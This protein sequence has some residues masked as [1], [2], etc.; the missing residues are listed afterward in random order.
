MTTLK[1]AM[2]AVGSATSCE[3]LTCG[4]HSYC[5]MEKSSGARCMCKDGYQGDGFVCKTAE[6][7]AL[8]SLSPFRPD[9]R[10]MQIADVHVSAIQGDTIMTVY[11]D[12]TDNHRGYAMLGHAS[13]DKMVW[14]P[15]TLF[16]RD[17]QAFSPVAVQLIEGNEALKRGGIAIAYRDMNRGGDGILLSGRIDH[18]SGKLLLGSPRAFAK[19]QAQT[20]SMLALPGSRV[21]IF[22]ASHNVA[23][24]D[25][26][27]A[28]GGMHG[29][30]M[31]A[32]AHP[33][34]SPPEVI[35]KKH[36][37]TGPVARLAATL[38]SP[39]SFVIA[40]RQGASDADS[41]L[42]EAACNTGELHDNDV[43]FGLSPLLLEP[44]Q[45]QI[46]SRSV[47]LIAENTV[48]YTYHSGHEGLTKQAIIK[49]DPSSHLLEVVHG[50]ETIGNGATSVV[51]SVALLAESTSNTRTRGLR[52]LSTGDQQRLQTSRLLTFFDHDGPKPASARLCNMDKFGNPLGCK[53]LLW[54]G[55]DMVSVSGAQVRDGRYV[56][57]F[58]DSRGVPYYQFAGLRDALVS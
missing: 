52:F 40:Y 27:Q 29:T 14:H 18:A 1:Q 36:F 38:L 33:D 47:S 22:Y 39:T 53:E 30:A 19:H 55:R 31:L 4:E 44:E 11:R 28:P 3:D 34:G 56:F 20:M 25:Q 43:L 48:A 51:G 37:A 42:A 2:G 49:I 13:P 16:S 12:M 35:G 7:F 21:I 46:W 23:K 45:A 15:P 41:K 32:Q 24:D 8:H 9:Q 17:S 50:P 5:T 6:Q 58:T 26:Q 54:S 10:Q 57:V